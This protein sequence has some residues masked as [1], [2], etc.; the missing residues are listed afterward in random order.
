MSGF[1][2][3][4]P[5]GQSKRNR[6]SKA[7]KDEHVLE[8]VLDAL[9]SAEIEE[10]GENVDVDD[11]TCKDGYLRESQ[12]DTHTGKILHAYTLYVRGLHTAIILSLSTIHVCIH[13]VVYYSSS[14]YG[15]C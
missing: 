5:D 8:A 10:E 14:V 4:V 6:T 3:R 15:G 11:T 13:I 9:G 12:G 1:A 7:G 2:L